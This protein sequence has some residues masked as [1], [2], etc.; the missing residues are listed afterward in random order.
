MG[1][2]PVIVAKKVTVKDGRVHLWLADGSTHSFPVAF[3]PRLAKADSNALQKVKLRLGGKAL[4][5]E[6]LDE[7]I[8]IGHAV[9][10]RY[11]KAAVAQ[12]L[13]AA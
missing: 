11:P 5:W 7:D 2:E 12:R 1:Y 8:W 3:Y 4:R 13:A 6:A 10:G 9:T